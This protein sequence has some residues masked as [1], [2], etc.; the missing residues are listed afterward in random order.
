MC[1]KKMKLVSELCP[2]KTRQER[3]K[4]MKKLLMITVIILIKIT[5]VSAG[6]AYQ[7]AISASE[8]EYKTKI[9]GVVPGFIGKIVFI[10]AKMIIVRGK[11]VAIGFDAKNPTLRG[12]AAIDDVRVGDTV[13]AK[14]MKDGIMIT[15][16]KGPAKTRTVKTK[17]IEKA[18]TLTKHEAISRVTDYMRNENMELE[19]EKLR[20]ISEM[21]YDESLRYKLD[22]R[23]VL[24]LMKIESNFRHKAVSKKGA[25]GLLQ[26]KPSLARYVADGVGVTWQGDTTLDEPD[27]NIKIG[28]H[29]FSK[30]INDFK[31]VQMALHAYHVGPTRLREILFEEKKPQ[32]YYVNLVLDEYDKNVLRF[33]AP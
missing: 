13:A 16:L 8:K 24:A 20:T 4:G 30:L 31:S 25:R 12:C 22:Y 29:V 2:S 23:L 9:K 11:R 26:I 15:K 27:K 21:V 19:D 32:K 18:K 28:V 33:P 17:K 7:T 10:D 1:D 3:G 6:F 5:F 14:Y